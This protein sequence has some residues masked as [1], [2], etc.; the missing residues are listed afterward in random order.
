IREQ[1]EQQAR[2]LRSQLRIPVET[3]QAYLDRVLVNAYVGTGAT[4]VWFDDLEIGGVVTPSTAGVDANVSTTRIVGDEHASIDAAQ[5]ELR[6]Q[7][8]LVGGKP[9]F[10][11]IVEHRGEPPAFL[12]QL[13]FN[14]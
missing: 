9:F 13:G 6:G 8:L 4:R 1:V 14:T 11:R 7:A 3:G 5:V 10:P 12:Q 2:V